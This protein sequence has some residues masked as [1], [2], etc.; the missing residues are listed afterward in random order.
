M[1][2]ALD[3]SIIIELENGNKETI[4]KILEI[5]KIHQSICYIPFVCYFEVYVGILKKIEKNQKQAYTFL[6][7]FPLL[8]PTKKTAE[9]LAEMKK[10]YEEQGKTLSLT[11]LLIASQIQEHNFLLITKDKDF[12][13]V[14]EIKKIIF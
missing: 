3:T 9:I 1:I 13:H 8:Q 14:E 7:T 12:E 6:Q 2:L 5:K 11:D 4:E 10:K